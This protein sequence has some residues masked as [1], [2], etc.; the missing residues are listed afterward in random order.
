MPQARPVALTPPPGVVKT[1]GDRVIQ[2]R[3]R[4]SQMMRCQNG[5]P[6][7]RGGHSV[8]TDDVTSG[9]PRAMHAWRDLSQQDYT[10]VGTSKKLYCYDRTFDQKN[11]TPI[12][13]SGTLGN[14]PFHT[15]SGSQDRGCGP[16]AFGLRFRTR[17]QLAECA[18][19]RTQLE[20]LSLGGLIR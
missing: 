9:V 18:I 16:R 6:Q 20:R 14:N 2:G 17:E 5:K 7:K 15:T 12:E 1:E 11:I 3:Y 19:R 10:G 4:D 13:K 8:A